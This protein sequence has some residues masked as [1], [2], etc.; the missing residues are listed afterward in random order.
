[1][2]PIATQRC[3]PFSPCP[4]LPL[5]KGWAQDSSVLMELCRDESLRKRFKHGFQGAPQTCL[6]G[7][8]REGEKLTPTGLKGRERNGRWSGVPFWFYLYKKF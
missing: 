3:A 7:I 6:L 8:S 4:C 5:Q 2:N 1:M